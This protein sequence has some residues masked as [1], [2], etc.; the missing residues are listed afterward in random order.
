MMRLF[1]FT[2]IIGCEVERPPARAA[3]HHHGCN[4]K[5]QGSTPA[6]WTA[7]DWEVYCS[8]VQCKTPIQ[9]ENNG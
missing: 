1:I 4:S 6:C 5:R 2:F 3:K 8:R 9:E 7:Q